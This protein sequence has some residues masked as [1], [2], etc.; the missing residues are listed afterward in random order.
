MYIPSKF[1]IEDTTKLARFIRENSFATLIT[2]ADGVPFA[3]HLPIL[4][5]PN[6]PPAGKLL[7]HMARANPQWKH[8]A[9]G[10]EI[11]AVFHGPHAYISPR[12]Y[13]TSP[14]VPTWNYTVVHAYGKPRLIDNDSELENLLDRTIR[15][16]E[17][18]R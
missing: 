18:D 10:R 2:Q 1:K 17:G 5:E 4:F 15:F 9:D 11:L 16:Y 6:S 3:S 8:F 12:W 14:Q 7:G 13:K